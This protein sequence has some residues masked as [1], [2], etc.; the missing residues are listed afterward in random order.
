MIAPTQW[1]KTDRDNVAGVVP[2][3]YPGQQR[4]NRRSLPADLA[5]FGAFLL[6]TVVPGQ[7]GHGTSGGRDR[8]PPP[9][10][11]ASCPGR[12]PDRPIGRL[13]RVGD[14]RACGAGRPADLPGDGRYAWPA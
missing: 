14:G 3:R 10:R 4:D 2:Q 7:P 9:S 12:C 11:G 8:Q 5:F 6:G 13:A 1:G